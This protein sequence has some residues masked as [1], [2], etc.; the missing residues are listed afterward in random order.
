[1]Y[2]K[3]E[4]ISLQIGWTTSMGT[5]KKEGGKKVFATGWMNNIH[6]KNQKGEK[7]VPETGWMNNI[8]GNN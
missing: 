3:R 8:H 4:L 6:G 5:I 7:K 2:Q 1:V